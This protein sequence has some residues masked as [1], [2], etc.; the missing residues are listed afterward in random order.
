VT[1]HLVG[2]GPGDAD[3]LTLRAARLLGSADVVVH[4]RLID[5]AVLALAPRDAELIDVG[6]VPGGSSTQ[7]IINDLLI[8][9]GR[10]HGNVVRLKG[11]DPFVFGRGGEEMIALHD[12]GVECDVVPGVTSAFSGPL[13]AGIPVTHR[14]VARG[15]TVVTGHAFDDDDDYFRRIA[16]PELSLVILMGVGRRASIARQL[17]QGGLPPATPVAV[18]EN[19]W[20]RRQRVV[21]GTLG[22]LGRLDVS[23]P[24]IIVV[25]PTAALRLGDVASEAAARW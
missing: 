20:S 13:A 5:A 11:G 4:D 18:V 19:A 2:A 23:S 14:G 3:L 25:G 8:S 16:H 21:R 7:S 22:E 17:I 15:V 6:K 1:V 12:A 24:A 10:R 9:L